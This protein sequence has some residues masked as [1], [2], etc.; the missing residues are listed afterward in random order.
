M[1]VPKKGARTCLNCLEFLLHNLLLC[2]S[3]GVEGN[4]DKVGHN[5]KQV[6]PVHGTLEEVGLARAGDQSHEEL[7]CE[8]GHVDSLHDGKAGKLASYFVLVL[9]KVGHCV[10]GEDDGRDE[11]TGN[12]D[13]AKD[14]G[15]GRRVWMLKEV[16]ELALDGGS[17]F[18][19][20]LYL[21]LLLRLLPLQL[22]LAFQPSLE[23]ARLE[24][25]LL[26]TPVDKIGDKSDGAAI[27]RDV[28]SPAAVEVED[29]LHV[30]VAVVEENLILC[31]I[32]LITVS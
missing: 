12:R 4:R 29:V 5:G 15:Q 2:H 16:P 24:A 6:D 18:R 3:I 28:K 9:L 14:T 27:G 22:F 8:V 17:T 30:L 7:D 26:E 32:A 19:E 11:D 20:L 31:G 10:E 13:D 1:K 25:S 23:A 21:H